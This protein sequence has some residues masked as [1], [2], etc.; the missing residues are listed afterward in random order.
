MNIINFIKKLEEP[1]PVT[2]PN[3]EA[4]EVKRE[5]LE[6]RIANRDYAEL[7]IKTAKRTVKQEDSLIRQ[8]LYCGMSTYTNDPVNLGIVAPTSEGKTYPV[9]EV[10]N[11]F[12][13][14]DIWYVGSMSPKVLIRQQGVLVDNNNEPI[15][16]KIK[17]LRLVLA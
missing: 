7:F 8:I 13:K 11:F 15:D 16:Y 6:A 10:M 17:Q 14:E 9:I 4:A 5:D 1:L 12:P 2:E 3:L